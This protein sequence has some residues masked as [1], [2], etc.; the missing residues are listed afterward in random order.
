Q[1]RDDSGSGAFDRRAHPT[2][3]SAQGPREGDPRRGYAARIRNC[4]GARKES[5]MPTSADL[6]PSTARSVRPLVKDR[7]N[8]VPL[9]Y[10]GVSVQAYDGPMTEYGIAS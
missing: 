9:P 1:G 4:L 10:R 6:L 8:V 5:L 2:A 7:F 3:R